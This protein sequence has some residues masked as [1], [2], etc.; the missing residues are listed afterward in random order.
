VTL[1]RDIDFTQPLLV[2]REVV[3]EIRAPGSDRR[4]I[5]ALLEACLDHVRSSVR[6]DADAGE[7]LARRWT[8]GLDRAEFKDPTYARMTSGA[9]DA[10]MARETTRV[11]LYCRWLGGEVSDRVLARELETSVLAKAEHS[12]FGHNALLSLCQ[13]IRHA[14]FRGTVIG[15]DEAEQGFDVGKKQ[16]QRILS[17]LQSNINAAADLR[18]GSTLLVYAITPDVADRMEEFP[19]LQQRVADPAPGQGFFDGNPRASKIDLSIRGDPYEELTAI[20]TRLVDLLYENSDKTLALGRDEVHAKV[21]EIAREV[22]DS[23]AAVSNRRTM[24]KRTATALLRLYETDHL[25][26]AIETESAPE[27]AEV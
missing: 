4:G 26:F 10:L 24:S 25:T 15:F 6:G 23:D 20:G 27:E 16:M 22:A 3:R 18:Q 7:K 14:R 19:A 8:A 12:R 9:F 13:L 2:Y 11:D 21:G 17:M 5:R 1:N